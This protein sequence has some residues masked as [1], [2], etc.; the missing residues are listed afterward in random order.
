[1]LLLNVLLSKTVI[2]SQA[3]SAFGVHKLLVD[4]VARWAYSR[5]H[6][7]A[8][9]PR[10]YVRRSLKDLCIDS[11]TVTSHELGKGAYGVIHAVEFNGAS[12]AGKQLHP[13]F[14]HGTKTEHRQLLLETVRHR[15]PFPQPPAPSKH[16]A[17]PGSALRGR[18]CASHA[19]DGA[20]GHLTASLS[21]RAQ[22]H[23]SGCPKIVFY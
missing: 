4:V 9:N 17:T 19:S 23:P 2:K 7:T 5:Q 22:Q 6:Q 1:M 12:C 3:T 11:V 15:M 16:S 18:L 14:F 20:N 8:W 13:V 21:G 10:D